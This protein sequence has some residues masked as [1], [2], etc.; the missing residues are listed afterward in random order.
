MLS[1]LEIRLPL[2]NLVMDTKPTENGEQFSAV[3]T[4]TEDAWKTVATHEVDIRGDDF[5]LISALLSVTFSQSCDGATDNAR[6]RVA[7]SEDNSTYTVVCTDGTN[8]YIDNDSAGTSYEEKTVT[9]Y[10]DPWL[11]TKDGHFWVRYQVC[12]D[13]AASD[14]GRGKVKNTGFVT[15]QVLPN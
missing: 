13:A 11:T 7:I 8:E 6:G 10:I 3:V 4:S 2:F 9:G 5:T 15:L 12:A 1:P 14:N